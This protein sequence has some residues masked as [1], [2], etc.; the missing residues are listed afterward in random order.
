MQ[1]HLRRKYLCNGVL[2]NLLVASPFPGDI[3]ANGSAGSLTR[4]TTAGP[5]TNKT[6]SS[7]KLERVLFVGGMNGQPFDDG[8]KS[9]G[10]NAHSR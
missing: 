3:S 7:R 4:S 2:L 10:G 9:K 5:L 1:Q 6:R 8:E